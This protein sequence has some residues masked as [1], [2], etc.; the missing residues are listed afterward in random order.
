M[1][2]T[3]LAACGGG[4]GGGSFLPARSGVV[5]SGSSSFHQF[6]VQIHPYAPDEPATDLPL[7]LATGATYVRCDFA[8]DLIENPAGTFDWSLYDTIYNNF[9]ENGIIP[10]FLT[11]IGNPEAYGF[12]T[13]ISAPITSQQIEEYVTFHQTA[14]AR[15]PQAWWEICNEPNEEYFWPPEP[16]AA[17]YAA[18]VNAVAPVI[19]A[20][21]ASTS[22]ILS[23]GTSGI[24]TDFIQ[25]YIEAGVGGLVDYVGFHPYGVDPDDLASSLGALKRFVSKPFFCTE[26]GTCDETTQSNDLTAMAQACGALGIPFIWYELLDGEPNTLDPT[27][28][29]GLYT[30]SL[31][32]KPVLAAAQAYASGNTASTTT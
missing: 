28:T 18:L 5:A 29:F 16:D 24:P 14:S 20:N 31:T 25:D 17:Q 32:P 6:G 21:I 8:W 4:G 19:R 9:L 10:I 2:A 27:N 15:Y 7:I 23:A 12:G 30:M 22:K 1:G 11:G 26:Y 3:A 13:G